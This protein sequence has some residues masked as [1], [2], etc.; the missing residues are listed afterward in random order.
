MASFGHNELKT[1]PQVKNRDRNGSLGPT[2]T[3]ILEG[4]GLS[5]SG[6]RAG[7]GFNKKTWSVP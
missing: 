3:L 1:E 2:G 6:K 7:D 5:Q 4:W